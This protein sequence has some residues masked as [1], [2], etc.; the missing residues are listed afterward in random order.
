MLYQMPYQ[1][2]QMYV[3]VCVQRWQIKILQS[4]GS[5][6]LLVNALTLLHVLSVGLSDGEVI[7]LKRQQKRKERFT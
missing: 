3:C 2:A 1:S 7:V 6:T 4:V 5:L